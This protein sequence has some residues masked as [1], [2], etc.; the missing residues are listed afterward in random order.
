[1]LVLER[2]VGEEITVGN[3]RIVVIRARGK[4]VH[5]GIDAPRSVTITRPDAKD[6]DGKRRAEKAISIR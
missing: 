3:I 2:G 5:I 1:M 6:S 4:R